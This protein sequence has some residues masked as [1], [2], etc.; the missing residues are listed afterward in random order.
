MWLTFYSTARICGSFTHSQVF[1]MTER[2]VSPF[3]RTFDASLRGRA[4]ST[5]LGGCATLGSHAEIWTFHIYVPVHNTK[6]RK[7]LGVSHK[8]VLGTKGLMSS[9]VAHSDQV[10][11]LQLTIY[12]I[13]LLLYSACLDRKIRVQQVCTYSTQR[14][15]PEFLYKVPSR[16][17]SCRGCIGKFCQLLGHPVHHH[18]GTHGRRTGYP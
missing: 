13:L 10:L 17:F 9:G 15:S 5:G 8:W 1:S 16:C 6:M 3:A 14:P 4:T 18:S 2:K 7:G 12:L 11:T